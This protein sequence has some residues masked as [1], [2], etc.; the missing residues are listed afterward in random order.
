MQKDPQV[1]LP[2]TGSLCSYS[3]LEISEWM[4]KNH[5]EPFHSVLSLDVIVG[6]T[7][8]SSYF[9]SGCIGFTYIM[10]F[11]L[12]HPWWENVSYLNDLVT[13]KALYVKIKYTYSYNRRSGSKYSMYDLFSDIFRLGFHEK[14]I[15]NQDCTIFWKVITFPLM[16]DQVFL[17][18]QCTDVHLIPNSSTRTV[19][20]A[21]LL[22]RIS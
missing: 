19:L 7:S 13:S 21:F 11:T 10:F 8:V 20:V 1:M 4:M 12:S 9:K 3:Y 18:G 15:I 2:I 6:E 5:Y 17:K 14:S 16:E 22:L